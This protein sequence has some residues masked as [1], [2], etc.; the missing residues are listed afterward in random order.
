M[1][2]HVAKGRLLITR[3][4]QIAAGRGWIFEML[5][6]NPA[7]HRTAAEPAFENGTAVTPFFALCCILFVGDA[8]ICS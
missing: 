8:G 5:T 6:K 1:K 3:V 2:I 4:S 7:N